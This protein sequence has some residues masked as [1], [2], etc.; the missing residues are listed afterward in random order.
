MACIGFKLGREM[1]ARPLLHVTAEDWKHTTSASQTLER[2]VVRLV[3][4]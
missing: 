1:R 3:E 2:M 4:V